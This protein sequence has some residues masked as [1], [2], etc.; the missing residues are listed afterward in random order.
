MHRFNIENKN[1][2]L[3]KQKHLIWNKKTILENNMPNLFTLDVYLHLGNIHQ[4]IY[5]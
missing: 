3:K 2:K 4:R 1:Y 5:K